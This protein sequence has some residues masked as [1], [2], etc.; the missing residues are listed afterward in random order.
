MNFPDAQAEGRACFWKFYFLLTDNLYSA[1]KKGLIVTQKKM[2]GTLRPVVPSVF[3]LSF[4]DPR[5]SLKRL[6]ALHT[7]TPKVNFS[8]PGG[9]G[10]RNCFFAFFFFFEELRPHAPARPRDGIMSQIFTT[11]ICIDFMAQLARATPHQQ[12]TLAATTECDVGATHRQNSIAART[13][14]KLDTTAVSGSSL[15]SGLSDLAVF[16]NFCGES[17]MPRASAWTTAERG[18]GS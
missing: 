12:A 9:W 14:R 8:K 4:L 3:K 7:R 10:V 5:L 16:S 11:I 15:D 1:K 18:C 17:T 13:T 2:T 6:G